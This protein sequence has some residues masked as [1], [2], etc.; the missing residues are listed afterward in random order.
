VAYSPE[1]ATAK[2]QKSYD[3]IVILY[4]KSGHLI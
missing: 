1:M 4:D 2:D 3:A